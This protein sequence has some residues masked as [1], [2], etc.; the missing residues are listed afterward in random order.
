VHTTRRSTRATDTA[1][2]RGTTAETTTCSNAKALTSANGKAGELTTLLARQNPTRRHL[3]GQADLPASF[4]L[5]TTSSGRHAPDHDLSK[6]RE[7]R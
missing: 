7:A 4:D 5:G 3:Q 2:S 6:Q 1:F